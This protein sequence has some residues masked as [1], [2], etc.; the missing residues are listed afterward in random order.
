MVHSTYYGAFNGF[1]TT[2]LAKGTT[3]YKNA[4]VCNRSIRDFIARSACDAPTNRAAQ[5]ELGAEGVVIK[6]A[7][8]D[9]SANNQRAERVIKYENIRMVTKLPPRGACGFAAIAISSNNAGGLKGANS[10][11][12]SGSPL[13][14]TLSKASEAKAF[15]IISHVWTPQ[16]NE[17]LDEFYEAVTLRL[18][19]R[20]RRPTMSSP[21]QRI[22]MM[23]QAS[24]VAAYATYGRGADKENTPSLHRPNGKPART[25][26]TDP[27]GDS[28]IING[29][30]VWSF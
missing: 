20:K 26:T 23:A 27:W 3:G 7:V 14:R 22:S 24:W 5:V 6:L 15:K 16:N 29:E 13:S 11:A 18:R 28:E 21:T 1:G 2:E 25:T 12:G 4:D 17:Q 30:E 8:R 19:K 9:Q 10:G